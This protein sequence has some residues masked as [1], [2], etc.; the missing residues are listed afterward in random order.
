MG[1]SRSQNKRET[2]MKGGTVDD[3]YKVINA[4]LA[5]KTKE[6]PKKNPK[7]P[8]FPPAAQAT[9]QKLR[10][11]IDAGGEQATLAYGALSRLSVLWTEGAIKTDSQRN[12][13]VFNL[14]NSMF[15]L[16]P[17]GEGLPDPDAP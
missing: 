12:A 1:K 17:N 4:E 2:V 8:T 10:E 16:F 11:I 7:V 14:L 9:A 15:L 5:K 13:V 6:K 3:V